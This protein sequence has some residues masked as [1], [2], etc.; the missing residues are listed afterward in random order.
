MANA[1][2]ATLKI[3]TVVPEGTHWMKEFR[4]AGQAVEESTEGRVKLKFYPG[5]VM[6][7]DQSVLRKM[8]IGQLNGGALSSGSLAQHYSGVNLYSLPFLFRNYDEVRAVRD[9]IDPVIQQELAK[10]GLVVL[11]ISEG[12]FAYMFSDRAVQSVED[13]K[14]RKV[15]VPEGD[16]ISRET[17]ESAGISPVALPISDVYTGLQ[18]GLIDTV[19]I[20]PTGAIALQWHT[21]VNAMTHEPLLFIMGMMVV[22][23]RAFMRLSTADQGVVKEAV[24]AAFGRLDQANRNNDE[25]ALKALE[26]NGI[27]IAPMSEANRAE[28]QKLADATLQRLEGEGVF[29]KALLSKV[30]E[31][32]AQL[33]G[34]AE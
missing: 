7:S 21:R 5:G 11:G 15:W 34:D 22:D 33:R 29:P 26:A 17:F 27:E 16:R 12:G 19:A 24:S 14:S 20:N 28:W 9:L 18:T 3:A 32:L 31:R 10:K 2:A 8:R 25:Q 23:K 4:A 6:G 1:S 13:I 30:R